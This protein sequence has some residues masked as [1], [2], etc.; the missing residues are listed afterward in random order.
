MNLSKEHIK[1]IFIAVLLILTGAFAYKYFYTPKVATPDRPIEQQHDERPQPGSF[2]EIIEG[3]V[4]EYGGN[5]IGDIDKILLQTST[6]KKWLHFPPHAAK[7]VLALAGKNVV[8]EAKVG[9]TRH[10]PENETVCE[11]LALRSKKSMEEIT[12]ADISPPPPSDGIETEIT[13][14]SVQFQYDQHGHVIGFVLSGKLVELRPKMAEV[15]GEILQNAKVIQVKG[16][17]RS[18]DD[19][20]VNMQGYIL[21][22]PVSIIIDNINY[23]V[24]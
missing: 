23:T 5:H 8:I 1:S 4:L 11:L 3:T 13:G 15:L 17:A 6:G 7:K 12:I 10:D 2:E 18:A 20:T 14:N 22:K 16:F 24:Q 21:V 19:G 9:D